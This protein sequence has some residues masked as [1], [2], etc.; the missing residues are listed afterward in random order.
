VTLTLADESLEVADKAEAYQ[1]LREQGMEWLKSNLL[2]KRD[3]F[4]L[5]QRRVSDLINM[6]DPDD[7]S[8][9]FLHPRLQ[10]ALS[11]LEENI[12]KKHP[13]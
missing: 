3:E 10:K 5:W 8:K 13:L 12:L 2:P 7:S 6:M 1:I 11:E 4:V 9:E